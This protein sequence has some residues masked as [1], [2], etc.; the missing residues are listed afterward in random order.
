VTKGLATLI[1]EN[2]Y[3]PITFVAISLSTLI[4][5]IFWLTMMYSLGQA[6]QVAI[7]E[8]KIAREA[9]RQ[10]YT[11]FVQSIDHRLSRIEGKLGVNG[12]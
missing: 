1:G 5:G 7:Q 3:I 6:N 9:D 10:A 12:E 11:T 4:G 2:T 8:L